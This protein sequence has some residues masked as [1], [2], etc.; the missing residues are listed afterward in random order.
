MERPPGPG[1]PGGGNRPMSGT[2]RRPALVL[3]LL[4]TAL[5]RGSTAR[6][7]WIASGTFLYTDREFNQNG[8]TGNM[9]HL[10]IRG[11]VMQVLDR[12]TVTVLA[13]GATD[14]LGRFRIPVID[15]QVRF[16]SVRAL[17]YAAD[18]TRYHL[19]VQDYPGSG[20]AGAL[21]AV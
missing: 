13:S 2:W 20:T 6:A 7:D 12:R 16:I 15:N 17:S 14:S 11:A 21:Y 5:S 1:V 9:P 18:S 19:R 10:P 3:L 4:A 8:F